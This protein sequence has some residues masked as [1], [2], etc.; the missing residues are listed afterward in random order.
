M[1]A[2]QYLNKST[3]VM[4]HY[5]DLISHVVPQSLCRLFKTLKLPFV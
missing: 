3:A 5:D 2:R 1:K 4:L